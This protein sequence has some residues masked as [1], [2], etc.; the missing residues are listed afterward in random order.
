M[1][2]AVFVEALQQHGHFGFC[3]GLGGDM[4]GACKIGVQEGGVGRVDEVTQLG[5]K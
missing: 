5:K 1:Q 2:A 3:A 4:Q